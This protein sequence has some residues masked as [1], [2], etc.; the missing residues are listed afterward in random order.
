MLVVEY[1]E[2]INEI[3]ELLLQ[4]CNLLK[5]MKEE[6]KIFTHYHWLNFLSLIYK[7]DMRIG[8][9]IRL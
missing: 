4:R 8:F 9:C 1:F 6:I 2:A 5:E 7:M 3:E